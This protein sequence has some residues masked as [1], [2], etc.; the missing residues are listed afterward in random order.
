MLNSTFHRSSS[1]HL[2]SAQTPRRRSSAT[3]PHSG[4]V[5]PAARARH[6]RRRSRYGQETMEWVGVEVRAVDGVHEYE[7]E[8]EEEEEETDSLLDESPAGSP[9]PA[10]SASVFLLSRPFSSPASSAPSSP[11]SSF[12]SPA[13][14]SSF[15][16][17][18]ATDSACSD[19]STGLDW[20][21]ASSPPT[22]PPS[23]GWSGLTVSSLLS[24][25]RSQLPFLSSHSSAS[26][27]SHHSYPAT[28]AAASHRSSAGKRK[29]FETRRA[30]QRRSEQ[31]NDSV[32]IDVRTARTRTRPPHTARGHRAV[33]V[34]EG[35]IAERTCQQRT[36]ARQSHGSNSKKRR[37]LHVLVVQGDSEQPQ[38]ERKLEGC[39]RAGEVG[40]GNAEQGR[41]L[42]ATCRRSVQQ[43]VESAAAAQSAFAAPPP[44]TLAP[45]H[46]TA[47]PSE[48]T[49]SQLPCSF[50]ALHSFAA[51]HASESV[52]RLSE[53][54]RSEV[55]QQLEADVYSALSGVDAAIQRE[56]HTLLDS[57]GVSAPQMLSFRQLVSRVLDAPND[58]RLRK[59]CAVE[60]QWT[61]YVLEALQRMND[62]TDSSP[63]ALGRARTRS[64][65]QAAAEQPHKQEPSACRQHRR[66]HSDCSGASSQ[67]VLRGSH[68]PTQPSPLLCSSLST[69]APPQTFSQF[70]SSASGNSY[71]LCSSP[72]T[73]AS[74]STPVPR[75]TRSALLRSFLS[76][77]TSIHVL[78][79]SLF[80]LSLLHTTDAACLRKSHFALAVLHTDAWQTDRARLPLSHPD[81]AERA[82]RVC[83]RE[84]EHCRSLYYLLDSCCL[85]LVQHELLP[86]LPFR[87]F[88]EGALP[89]LPIEHALG[90]R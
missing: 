1:S 49:S 56:L 82:R 29:R 17:P 35:V 88:D 3:F 25:V 32:V 38:P 27:S 65:C 58:K 51:S 87:S 72:L 48:S 84:A 63:P 42:S 89:Q 60:P 78:L 77:A 62:T 80:Y 67:P 18:R 6:E 75:S 44:L 46:R 23:S 37:M 47:R 31:R 83:S 52:A 8:E 20:S 15:S 36:R 53:A 5:R 54:A 2:H 28:A 16:S 55:E 79:C 4:N 40:A 71:I 11:S 39:E 90:L 76:S 86:Q 13:P 74:S 81:C 43:E 22:P 41:P 10:D 68:S 12:P 24:R 61:L 26:S 85:A 57:H 33:G 64:D 45:I 14:S 9:L 50:P 34:E 19:E 59:L 66:A 21:A 30:A 70:L 73:A 7:E 69:L